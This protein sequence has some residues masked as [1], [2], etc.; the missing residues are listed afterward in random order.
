MDIISHAYEYAGWAYA[1]FNPTKR[2]FLWALL[3]THSAECLEIGISIW[4]SS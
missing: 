2:I 1:F 3:T 4:S